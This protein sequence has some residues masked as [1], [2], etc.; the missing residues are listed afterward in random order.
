MVH[1]DEASLIQKE[2]NDNVTCS[3]N[4]DVHTA[5]QQTPSMLVLALDRRANIAYL[6]TKMK[7]YKDPTR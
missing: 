3:L 7:Q 2:M 5:P 4:N 1:C 6:W